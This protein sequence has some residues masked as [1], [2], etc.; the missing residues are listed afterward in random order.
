MLVGH[1]VNLSVVLCTGYEG[2]TLKIADALLDSLRS[3][4]SGWRKAQAC[5]GKV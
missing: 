2:K 4:G 3:E 1:D 5:P